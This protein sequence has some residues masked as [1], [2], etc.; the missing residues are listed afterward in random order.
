MNEDIALLQFVALAL[1]AI[2][3]LMQAVLSYHDA[4][5]SI[6]GASIQTEFRFLELAFLGLIGAGVIF[7]L[8]IF[9][10]TNSW[11]TKSGVLVLIVALATIFPAN[12]FALR[13]GKYPSRTYESP[14]EAVKSIGLKYVKIG[15]FVVIIIFAIATTGI[16]WDALLVFPPIFSYLSTDLIIALI[17]VLAIPLVKTITRYYLIQTALENW[18]E[19]IHEELDQISKIMDQNQ[20]REALEDDNKNLL[21]ISEPIV[22]QYKRSQNSLRG[23][24]NQAPDNVDEDVILELETLL[25]MLEKSVYNINEIEKIEDKIDYYHNQVSRSR[26]EKSELNQR[27]SDVDDEEDSKRIMR[28]K[29]TLENQMTRLKQDMTHAESR[30]ESRLRNLE[31]ILGEIYD[32][33]EGFELK[34]E[35]SF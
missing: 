8:S 2:A 28:E 30:K 12:W 1:P 29:A 7:S 35:N 6:G 5:G 9:S 10:T 33:C 11:Y 20:V 31:N 13:R 19:D 26:S 3:L 16:F 15:A 17:A 32:I 27:L 34:S 4:H 18:K 14:E 22:E 25:N 24:I 21:N 23:L